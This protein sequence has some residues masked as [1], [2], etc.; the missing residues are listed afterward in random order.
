[1]R[2]TISNLNREVKDLCSKYLIDDFSKVDLSLNNIPEVEMAEEPEGPLT[3]DNTTVE[4]LE[5]PVGGLIS[6]IPIYHR[7]IENELKELGVIGFDGTQLTIRRE[8]VAFI[9]TRTAF[10]EFTAR[11]RCY[12]PRE[13]LGAYHNG[14]VLGN[15]Q[16]IRTTVPSNS[17]VRSLNP[18]GFQPS[19]SGFTTIL[20]SQSELEML[21]FCHQRAIVGGLDW[22][23]SD[24]SLYQF[25]LGNQQYQ[26]TVKLAETALTNH[27]VPIGLVKRPRDKIYHQF[28]SELLNGH[29]K[30][31]DYADDRSFLGTTLKRGE[32][33]PF[34]S[35]IRSREKKVLT[36]RDPPMFTYVRLYNGSIIRIELPSELGVDLGE[37]VMQKFFALSLLTGGGLIRPNYRAHNLCKFSLPEQRYLA[38]CFEN[39]LRKR[40]IPANRIYEGDM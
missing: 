13:D 3:I 33:T 7:Q 24:G 17:P 18:K 36:G 15:L 30:K 34:I 29:I 40:K 28:T 10:S 39:E 6:G 22:V 31:L 32:R 23:V 5:G 9:H 26:E 35:I 2:G 21:K 19:I 12:Y 38:R 20:R 11:S 37:D 4:L 14:I 8:T 25:Y 27:I 1:M 16:I